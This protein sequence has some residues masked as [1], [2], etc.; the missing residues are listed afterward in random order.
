MCD[1]VID[2]QRQ[3]GKEAERQKGLV[4]VIKYESKIL[5]A[6]IINIAKINM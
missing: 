5:P 1:T 2:I 3:A 4:S 6:K